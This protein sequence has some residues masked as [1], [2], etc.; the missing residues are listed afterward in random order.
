MNGGEVIYQEA[1]KKHESRVHPSFHLSKL[2][3]NFDSNDEGQHKKP[4]E[5]VV[6]CSLKI[7]QKLI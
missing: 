3:S 5:Y 1:K 4:E 6:C 7:N 2:N